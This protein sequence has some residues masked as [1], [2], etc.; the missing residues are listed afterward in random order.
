MRQASSERSARP[1]RPEQF[2]GR[3]EFDSFSLLVVHSGM[4]TGMPCSSN[5][6]M[7]HSGARDALVA[8]AVEQ[9]EHLLRLPGAA[10]LGALG[11]RDLDP[12]LVA[13]LH[14]HALELTRALHA[15]RRRTPP[16]PPAKVRNRPGS[17]APNCAALQRL[18][19]DLLR[20]TPAAGTT[21]NDSNASSADDDRGQQ[22]RS[23]GRC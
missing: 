6:T 14:E 15:S 19:A 20:P 1:S 4:R 12:L 23:A 10:L 3:A 22:Q 9:H 7:R 11:H 8:P 16:S 13:P 2:A 18:D 17:S 5:S 21:R